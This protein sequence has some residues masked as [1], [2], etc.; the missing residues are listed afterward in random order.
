[1]EKKGGSKVVRCADGGFVLN[2]RAIHP[3]PS[4]S[5]KVQQSHAFSISHLKLLP[6]H[7]VVRVELFL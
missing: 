5:S 2:E 6:Q 7:H 3:I 4:L 1:M